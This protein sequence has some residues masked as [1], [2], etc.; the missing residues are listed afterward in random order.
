MD[1]TEQSIIGDPNPDFQVG[2]TNSIS[3]K[4]FTLS[5]LVDYTHGGDIYSVFYSVYVR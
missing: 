2:V 4:G 5:A 3:Y 1:D